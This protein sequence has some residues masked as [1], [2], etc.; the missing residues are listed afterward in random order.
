MRGGNQQWPAEQ[1]Q[2]VL[3]SGVSEVG[4]DLAVRIRQ[5]S[6]ALAS[7]PEFRVSLF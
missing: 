5:F 1:P 2:C 7:I 6:F 3:L 4:I